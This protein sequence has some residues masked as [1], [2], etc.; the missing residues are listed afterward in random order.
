M[1]LKRLKKP[2]TLRELMLAKQDEMEAALTSNRRIMPHEGEKGAAAELRWR[3]MLA[4]YLPNRYSVRSG[5]VVDHRGDVSDQIDVIIHDAQ[6]SPFLFQAGTSVFVP[7]ESVYAIFDAKQELSKQTL[8]ETGK[9][10]ASV[11]R[12]D[13]TSGQIWTNAGGPFPGKDPQKQHI[14]GGILTVTASWRS[15]P[16]G[17]PFFAALDEMPRSHSLDV[18][19]AVAAGAFSSPR[20]GERTIYDKDTALVGFFTALIRSLQPL[21]TA[22]AMDLE[23]WT[24]GLRTDS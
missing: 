4:D 22:L 13:R 21:A 6:Y 10:V 18:G 5:F 11:R 16:F 12:L 7:A 3:D 15:E 1:S 23:K 14:L 24:E 8:D 20:G 17:S 9:K 2:P 19:V